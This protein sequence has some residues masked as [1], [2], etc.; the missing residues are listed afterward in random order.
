M[1]DDPREEAAILLSIGTRK[2]NRPKTI[3]QTARA[4]QA[5]LKASNGNKREVAR[6][7]GLKVSTMIDRFLGVLDLPQDLQDKTSFGGPFG[8]DKAY[9]VSLLDDDRERRILVDEI[10]SS[11]PKLSTDE[12]R[13]IVEF[14]RRSADLS[15]VE[16]IRLAKEYREVIDEIQVLVV[17]LG[18]EAQRLLSGEFHDKKEATDFARN[19][20][21]RTVSDASQIRGVTLQERSLTIIMTR[22]G[23]AMFEDSRKR[24]GIDMVDFVNDAICK[25]AGG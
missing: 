12:V 20:L 13:Q 1:S 2:K 23:F 6:K 7:R 21:E 9:R 5:D 17:E 18:Q 11:K 3:V 10:F 14:R 15:I 22:V 25:G 4:L 24:A 16:A 19:A 8:V